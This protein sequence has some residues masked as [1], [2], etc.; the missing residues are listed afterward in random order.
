[1]RTSS[2]FDVVTLLL[3]SRLSDAIREELGGTYSITVQSQSARIP[4][5]EY[6]LRIDWTCDPARTQSLVQRVMTEVEFCQADAA[7]AGTGVPCAGIL[8][9]D[10]EKNSEDNGYLLAQISRRY[11]D[12][13]GA[14]VGAAVHPPQQISELSGAVIQQAAQRYLDT[15]NYVRVTLMPET[16]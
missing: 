3:Q 9:Q 11:D 8:A 14:N 13:D 2:P 15:H 1:M 4:R 16:K 12:G 6:R 10:F 7:H 5:P